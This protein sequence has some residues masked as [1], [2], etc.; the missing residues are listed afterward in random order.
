MHKLLNNQVVL[1]MVLF[2]V[3]KLLFLHN[4]SNDID[5]L[6]IAATEWV[7]G[8]HTEEVLSIKNT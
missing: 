6:L 3:N 7:K 8:K 5:L 1:I 2:N 4:A